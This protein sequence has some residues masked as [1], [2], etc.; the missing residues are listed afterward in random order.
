MQSNEANLKKNKY[1]LIKI[2]KKYNLFNLKEK[3]NQ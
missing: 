3:K 1:L 2:G